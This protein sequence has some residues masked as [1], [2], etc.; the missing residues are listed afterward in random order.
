MAVTL[1]TWSVG[2]ARSPCLGSPGPQVKVSSSAWWWYRL[3]PWASMK[4]EAAHSFSHM[5]RFVLLLM[6]LGLGSGSWFLALSSVW[7]GEGHGLLPLGPLLWCPGN[8]LS[9]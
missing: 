3:R 2:W 6:P 5:L 1:N 4:H 9:L 8:L 7:V